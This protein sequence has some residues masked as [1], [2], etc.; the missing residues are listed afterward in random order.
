MEQSPHSLPVRVRWLLGIT[1]A[2]FIVG[3][4]LVRLRWVYTHNK[5]LRVVAPGRFYRSGR[6]TVAGLEEA[7]KKYH[8]RTVINLMDEDPDPQLKRT[9]FGGG[10]ELER[11]VCQRHG[12][13]FVYLFVDT[14]SPNAG[15]DRRPATIDQYLEILDNPANYPVLLHCQAGLHRTGILSALYRMEY[16][17]WTAAQAWQ[18]LRNNGFGE[19]C[20]ADNDYI[21]QY[22]FRYQRGL[23]KVAQAHKSPDS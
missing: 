23:R 15:P 6:M 11:D 1:L 7:L 18:E 19:N 2:V 16:E 13:K 8:I 10:H 3:V 22:L 20:Y 12:A 9:F 17:D 14:I 5:R 21:M 4:P